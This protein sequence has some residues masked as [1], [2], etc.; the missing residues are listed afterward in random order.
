MF[1]NIVIIVLVVFAFAISANAVVVNNVRSTGDNNNS[2]S[3]QVDRNSSSSSDDGYASRN[4]TG[5][6]G[7]QSDE[8]NNVEAV[9][10]PGTL[11]L[12]GLGLAGASLSK[13]FRKKSVK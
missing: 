12:L 11:I 9:P 7:F 10:E 3:Q 6:M 8:T 1:K 5:S 4:G 2:N 13:R